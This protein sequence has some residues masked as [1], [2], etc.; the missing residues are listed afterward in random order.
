MMAGCVLKTLSTS[1]NTWMP[2][3]RTPE[4]SVYG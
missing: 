2:W 3:V 1:M 4:K